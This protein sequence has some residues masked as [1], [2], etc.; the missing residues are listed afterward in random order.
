MGPRGSKLDQNCTCT[1]RPLDQQHETI[2]TSRSLRYLVTD[3]IEEQDIVYGQTDRRTDRQTDGR[4]DGR[5]TDKRVSH[6]LDWSLTSRVKNIG[7]M[8]TKERWKDIMLFGSF[9][10]RSALSNRK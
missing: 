2:N 4:T 5:T 6:K 7:R 9:F 10:T 1:T 8:Y 3:E